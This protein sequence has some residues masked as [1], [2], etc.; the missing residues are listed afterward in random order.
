VNCETCNKLLDPPPAKTPFPA[1]CSAHCM[2]AWEERQRDAAMRKQ[3]E[4]NPKAL[5]ELW[6]R[7]ESGEPV[8]KI[9][10]PSRT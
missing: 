9:I 2:L 5:A 1:F 7:E 4:P 3:V 8:R 10:D 6:E